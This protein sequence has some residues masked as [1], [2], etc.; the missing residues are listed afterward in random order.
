MTAL[1]IIERQHTETDRHIAVW[2]AWWRGKYAPFHEYLEND[3]AGHPVRREMFRMNMAK[4]VCEDWAS[5]LLNDRTAISIDDAAGEEFVK[6]VFADT[7]FLRQ[8]N[9]LIERA[10]AVGTGAAILRLH[11]C[12]VRDGAIAA[13]ASTRVG[14]ELVDA[15]HIVPLSVENG[16]ITEAAFVSESIRRGKSYIYVESHTIE[17]GEYVIKNTVFRLGDDGEEYVECTPEGSCGAIHTGSTVPLFSIISPNIVNPYD[18]GSGLG[19][20][21][22]ADALD[23]LRGVDLAFNNFCRDIRL[24]G[25]KVFINQSLVCRDENGNIYS[26]DDLAKQLFVMI[27]DSDISERPMITEHNPELRTSENAEA[28]QCQLDYLS[29][30]CGLGTHHYSFT[31]NEGRARLTATQYMGERQDMLQN[32][33]KHGKN[34]EAFLRGVIRALLWCAEAVFCM[35]VN[36]DA[37]ITVDFDD[38]YFTDTESQ[39]ERSLRELEAGIITAEEYRKKWID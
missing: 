38:S 3:C 16:V 26:P 7:G 11:G 5:I 9:R 23:C 24:G 8:A 39:R 33:V 28:V 32:A 22:F 12:V 21:V 10:F 14:F 18:D 31:G 20:S 34:V 4:K 15:A 25:K 13:G 36:T 19:C 6:R 29:F 35:P 30:R 27:G 37:A 1:Q 2:D 17:N